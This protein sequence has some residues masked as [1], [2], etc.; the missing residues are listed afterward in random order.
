MNIGLNSFK[1]MNKEIKLIEIVEI[2]TKQL[3]TIIEIKSGFIELKD[4]EKASIFRDYE[5][6]ITTQLDTIQGKKSIIKEPLLIKEHQVLKLN[7]SNETKNLLN[8]IYK[9]NELVFTKSLTLNIL[10]NL[11]IKLSQSLS[12]SGIE[13]NELKRSLNNLSSKYDIISKEYPIFTLKAL[14][15]INASFLEVKLTKEKEITPYTILLCILRN[16][17]DL[18]T[19]TLN[20]YG[21]TYKNIFT[22]IQKMPTHNNV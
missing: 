10:N 14:K 8:T 18:T 11:D 7:F 9:E 13:L 3:N 5:K 22:E 12:K 15:A 4:Y 19:K 6:E 16:E 17:N 1:K 21:I 2:L 20:K